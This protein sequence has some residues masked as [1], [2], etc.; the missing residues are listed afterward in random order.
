MAQPAL[1]RAWPKRAEMHGDRDP[2][3]K[4][5]KS[6]PCTLFKATP[7][8][9]NSAVKVRPTTLTQSS[10]HQLARKTLGATKERLGKKMREGRDGFVAPRVG[11][12]IEHRT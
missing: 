5:A 6:V 7:K 1:S 10:H 3:A 4:R 11:S 2:K 9:P 8:L 12:R